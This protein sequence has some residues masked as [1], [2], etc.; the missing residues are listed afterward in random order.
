[1]SLVKYYQM[2]LIVKLEGDLR[3]DGQSDVNQRPPQAWKSLRT[4]AGNTT[5]L[6][7]RKWKTHN[8]TSAVTRFLTLLFPYLNRYKLWR[9]FTS[10][11]SRATVLVCGTQLSYNLVGIGILTP[12]LEAGATSVP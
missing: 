9:T 12:G 8:S 6:P 2:T 5:T 1:M 7:P 10:T 3:A 4:S 11:L